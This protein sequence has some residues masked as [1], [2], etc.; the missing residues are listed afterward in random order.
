MDVTERS[1]LEQQWHEDDDKLRDN[2]SLIVG[3]YS[4]GLFAQAETALLEELG[5][6]S[7]LHVLDYGCG[8]GVTS[9]EL[10]RRGARVTAFDISHRR[11][12]DAMQWLTASLPGC[13]IDLLQAS[14]EQLPFADAS[15]DVVLGKQILHHLQLEIATSELA[16]VLKPGG[17]AIFLEPLIHNPIL[18]FYRSLTPHLRSP[19]EKALSMSDLRKMSH[20]FSYW[21]HEEFI[22]FAVVPVV[23][24]ALIKKQSH[25]LDRLRESLQRV[26]RR[27]TNVIPW[28]GRYYWETVVVFKK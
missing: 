9:A 4:S 24:Q 11:L 18:E 8:T 23:V 15:F 27:L 10:A 19:T 28:L 13:K 6:I 17:R 5:D 3:V 7:G 20:Y 21:E 14:A 12:S 26:D 16:R 1:R 22:L 2:S 25:L